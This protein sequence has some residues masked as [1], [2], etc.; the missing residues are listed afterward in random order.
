VVIILDIEQKEE[1]KEK[2][3]LEQVFVLAS[4]LLL[5]S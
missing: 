2:E 4:T 1:G 5:F 3:K